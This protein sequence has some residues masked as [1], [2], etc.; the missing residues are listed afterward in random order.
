MGGTSAF[1]VRLPVKLKSPHLEYKSGGVHAGPTQL[2]VG[3]CD[4]LCFSELYFTVTYF[5]PVLMYFKYFIKFTYIIYDEYITL[6]NI[7]QQLR[8][9]VNY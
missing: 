9:K 4:G 5:S 3:R 1:Q 8:V 7:I 2:Y 6:I